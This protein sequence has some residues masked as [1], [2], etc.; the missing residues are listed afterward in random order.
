M[1]LPP[2]TALNVWALGSLHRVEWSL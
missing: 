1:P 2:P